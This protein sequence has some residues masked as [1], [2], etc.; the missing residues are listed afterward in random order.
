MVF[1]AGYVQGGKAVFI[2]GPDIRPGGDQVFHSFGIAYF[3][4][5]VQTCVA[6]FID[7]FDIF[8]ICRSAYQPGQ[9]RHNP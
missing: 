1:L 4:G 3:A 8:G 6:V 2:D 9:Q 5:S 7:C